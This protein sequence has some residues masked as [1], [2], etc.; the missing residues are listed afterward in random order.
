MLFN[1]DPAA[2]NYESLK[3]IEEQVRLGANLAR[4]LLAFARR[5]K[6]EVKISDVNK[7]LQRTSA[8]FERTQ[9]NSVHRKYQEDLG[10]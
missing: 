9:A 6:Y 10:G 5:G 8:L 1:L 7:I 3:R 4:Q 2:P